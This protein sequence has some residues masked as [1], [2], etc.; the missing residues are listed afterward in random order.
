MLKARWDE[1]ERD[2][3]TGL[4]LLFLAWYGCSTPPF[5]TGLYADDDAS[6]F[7]EVF[8]HF[9]GTRS[10]EPELL[11]AVGLMAGSFPWCCGGSLR[12]WSWRARKCA[13]TATRLKPAGFPASQFEGRG[14]Y[15]QYFAHMVTEGYG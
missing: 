15:G 9:G 11:Y 2:L 14:A 12:K 6:V 4:R 8:N 7:N 1:N 13:K 10:T 5:E 3:E